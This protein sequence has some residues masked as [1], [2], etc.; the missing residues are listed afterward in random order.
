ML[1]INNNEIIYESPNLKL[2]KKKTGINLLT[3]D[4]G[5]FRD[6]NGQYIGNIVYG[7]IYIENGIKKIEPKFKKVDQVFP[8]GHIWTWTFTGKG[9][10][11]EIN[12]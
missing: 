11:Y 10:T 12:N 2:F 8:D 4:N 9:Y 5:F 7:Y 1:D 3:T 6:E